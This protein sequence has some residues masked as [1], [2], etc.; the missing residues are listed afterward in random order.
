VATAA[1]L[2]VLAGT[3]G[4]RADDGTSVQSYTLSG[5]PV[6]GVHVTALGLP[7][8][9]Q[10]GTAG[11]AEL[12]PALAAYHDSGRY[13]KDIAAVAA[14]AKAYVGSRLAGAGPAAAPCQPAKY[15]RIKRPKGKPALY[16]RKRVPCAV[17]SP[18]VPAKPAIVLDIDETSLSNYA[19]LAATGFTSAG[20]GLALSAG[21]G[22]APAIAPVL[23]LFRY[24]RDHGVATFFI[25][26]R[27]SLVES[28]T[29]GNLKAAG[30]TGYTKLFL[31]PGGQGTLT[32]KAGTREQLEKDG[33]TI[34]A[35]VGDQDSDL[36]GGHAERAFKIPNPYYFISE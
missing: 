2:L 32:Y 6:D 28:Q 36:A 10:H 7:D 17:S 31:K 9:G 13:E 15:V 20:A 35:N 4:A 8:I 34:V 21:A 26:G 14:R 16:R 22:G 19:F 11:P 24:A 23:A 30:Y 5:T 1:I 25:T 3:L 12:A 29:I 27:P 18:V 33:Y